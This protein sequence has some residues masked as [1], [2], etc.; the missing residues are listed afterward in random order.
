MI[1]LSQL[2][3]KQAHLTEISKPVIEKEWSTLRF[4]MNSNYDK[5]HMC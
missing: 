2:K 5:L 3:S 4:E 1:V